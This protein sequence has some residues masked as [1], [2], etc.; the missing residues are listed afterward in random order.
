MFHGVFH[1]E[2]CEDVARKME[3]IDS[4]SKKLENLRKAEDLIREEIELNNELGQ[5]VTEW[6]KDKTKS[7]EFDKYQRFVDELD[8]ITNL[9]LS[10]S[11]RLARAQNALQN[12]EEGTDPA[13]K[14]EL[15]DKRDRLS[16]QYDDAKKLKENIDNRK[17]A[18]SKILSEYFNE[19]QFAD[20]E[21]FI[22]MK[23]QLIMESRELDDKIKLGEEQLRCLRENLS[24]ET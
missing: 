23:S 20:F 24:M 8:K 14:R 1:M 4:I 21:H 3:L 13:E 16:D 19:E 9:L 5:Q 2:K 7:N 17:D 10:L 22:K 6:A 18:V 12:I 15:Q 11:G